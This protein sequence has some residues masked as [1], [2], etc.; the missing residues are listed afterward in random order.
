MIQTLEVSK[1][2]MDVMDVQILWDYLHFIP[3]YASLTA[4][5]DHQEVTTYEVGLGWP[6]QMYETLKKLHCNDPFN[7]GPDFT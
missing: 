5:L 1:I 3:N 7:F 4:L 2:K 6:S